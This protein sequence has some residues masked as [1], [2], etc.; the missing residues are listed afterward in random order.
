VA[1]LLSANGISVAHAA[2]HASNDAAHALAA[3]LIR[4]DAAHT[5]WSVAALRAP[6]GDTPAHL[7]ARA[8][9]PFDLRTRPDIAA[10]IS[11]DQG[12]V[13]E[14][15]LGYPEFIAAALFDSAAMRLMTPSGRSLADL[16][17]RRY[18]SVAAQA[19][20]PSPADD[21]RL[22]VTRSRQRS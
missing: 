2:V 17:A 16:I 9:R 21:R 1:R 22:T 5:R 14:R 18:G 11:K 4:G 19:R 6:N 3:M 15:T 7:A 10:L 12:T 8:H 20:A 13:L